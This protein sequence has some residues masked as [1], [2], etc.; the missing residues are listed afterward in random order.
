M[1]HA[2][3]R[4]NL[5]EGYHRGVKYLREDKTQP[6]VSVP[7]ALILTDSNGATWTLG[8]DHVDK[9]WRYYWGIM[10][11]DVHT[12]EHAERLEYKNGKI[13]AWT[14][15]GP[16]VWVERSRRESS[17]SQSPGYWV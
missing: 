16:K 5:L 1:R 11:N 8:S 15:L 10:R 13:R 6:Y 14:P 17:M 3:F 4:D 9:G 7:P 12:G 2:V